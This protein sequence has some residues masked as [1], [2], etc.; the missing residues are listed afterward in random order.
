MIVLGA[1]LGFNWLLVFCKN[2]LFSGE[3]ESSL[4]GFYKM[5]WSRVQMSHGI[6][7]SFTVICRIRIIWIF[8]SKIGKILK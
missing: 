3:L 7:D 4:A 5:H 2:R 8:Y 6:Y 1:E